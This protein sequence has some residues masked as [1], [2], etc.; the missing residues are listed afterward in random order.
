MM[1][2]AFFVGMLASLA[3]LGSLAGATGAAAQ[4]RL[5]AVGNDFKHGLGDIWYIW[6]SPFHADARDWLTTLAVVGGAAAV[7]NWD[8]NVDAWIV[9]HPRAPL[10][11]AVKPFRAGEKPELVNLGSAKWIHPLGGV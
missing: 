6:S 9:S 4:G 8:D 1:P 5:Q 10:V 7:S 3:S 2:R 11:R